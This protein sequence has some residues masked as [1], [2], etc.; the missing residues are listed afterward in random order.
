MAIYS[1]IDHENYKSDITFKAIN[2]FN[3]EQL[4]LVHSCDLIGLVQAIQAANRAFLTWKSTDL[5]ERLTLIKK[6]GEQIEV[7]KKEFVQMES[8][9]QGLPLHITEEYSLNKI[10]ENL[11]LICNLKTAPDVHLQYSPVGV[12]AIIA[13]WNLSL[14]VILDRLLPALVAGNAVVI[15]VSSHSAVT[16][17]ILAEIVTAINAPKGLINVIV[18]DDLEVKRAIVAHPGIKAI[19]FV[20]KLEN[21]SEVLSLVSASSLQNFKKIQIS[22]GTKNSAVVLSEPQDDIFEKIMISFFAGQGQLAW[23]STRLFIIEKY[24]K[25]WVERIKNYLADLRP[26]EGIEDSSLWTPCLRQDSFSKYEEI[27]SISIA[28]QAKLLQSSFVLSAEQKKHFLPIS[29]TQDMS[30][31]STLQQDQIQTPFFILSTVK[32]PFDIPKYSNV[33]YY[34]FAAHLYGQV[35]KLSKVAESLDVGLIAY[36]KWSADVCGAQVGVKQSGFGIQDF[37]SFGSFFSNVKKMTN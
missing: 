31:C 16:A 32:Y 19:S 13:S 23:N 22:T 29:F 10:L 8:F 14:R 33:S 18:T 21:A 3:G 5:D 27:K 12:V 4:H 2:P 35:D 20:G 7:R 24:E 15:K 1:L 25:D 26:S 17:K 28:D 11:K 36:N 9:N 6:I 34:G 30:R 37:Q